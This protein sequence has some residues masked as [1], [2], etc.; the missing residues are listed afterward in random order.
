MVSELN[1]TPKA[2]RLHI[3]VFGSP[4][5]GKSTFI[6]AVTGQEVALVSPVKGTTT[7]PVYKPMELLPLGPVVFIDTAG[8]DDQTELG[9]LRTGKTLE[10]LPSCDGAVYIISTAEEFDEKKTLE[11]LQML[12][13]AKLPILLVV[14]RVGGQAG[15]CDFS[16][17]KLP[18]MEADL[19]QKDAVPAIRAQLVE[20]LRDQV[21]D[22]SLTG[23]LVEEGG[24]VLLVAP[25][26][27]QAP[28]GRLILPQVQTIRDL[29]DHRCMVMTVTADHLGAAFSSLHSPPSLV[30]T[31]SQLFR[32]VADSVPKGTRL[33]SFSMLMA[34]SKG[35]ISA[36][37]E[38]AY[39]IDTLK[40]GDRVL[41][42]ES[43]AH[44]EMDGDIA[45]Q[46][47]PAMLRKYTGKEFMITNVSGPGLPADFASYQL[48]IHCGGCMINRRAM[49]EKQKNFADSGVP[50]TNFGVAIAY[51]NGIL[52]QVCY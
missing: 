47:I 37:V 18:F 25:Q 13:A 14:N 11:H 16:S 33:T 8:L 41:I 51:M 9:A 22:T 29:L 28:K 49:L 32:Q 12:R 4:N 38:G 50:L 1:Q 34:R 52:G 39:A 3:G 40:D 20:L 35:D 27:I 2:L 42:L 46:K 17:W 7:D 15:S 45:R 21:E 30:I 6:N 10:Q 5:A 24:L 26:D 23:G 48:A 36:F 43:C 31:D 19:S 44:H